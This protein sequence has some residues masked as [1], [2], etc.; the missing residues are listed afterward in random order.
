MRLSNVSET[1]T[2]RQKY[3]GTESAVPV[4][5]LTVVTPH[6]TTAVR[7]L[8]QSVRAALSRQ[9]RI[10]LAASGGLDS[11]ALLDAAAST[12]PRDRLTIATFD[13][14]TGPAATAACELVA[15]RAASLGVEF[16]AERAAAQ[17]TSE[18]AFRTARWAFLRA[19]AAKREA[20]IATAHTEDDQIETILMRVMRDAGARGLAALYAESDVLRPFVR[21][22]R[23]ALVQYARAQALVWIED[24]SNV[25]RAYLRN[26]VRHE[27]LPALR[28]VW[29][30][31]DRDLL[32][33]ARDAA[34]LRREIEAH[35]D[36]IDGL[37]VLSSGRGLDAPVAAF[38]SR[39]AATLFWPAVAAKAR[40][41]LD[42]RGL[43]RLVAFTAASRVGSRIQLA[44]GWQVVRSR[45]AFQVRESNMNASDEATPAALALSE[46]T[47]WG[48]WSFRAGDP[49]V[50][51]DGDS[52]SAW[53]PSDRP[54]LV[55]RWG[56]GDAMIHR[57]GS[58]PR[59]VK[60]LLTAAG[61]TGHQRAGWPVVVAG[62]Q[63]VW[64]PGVRRGVAA[65]ARSGRPGL[66]F[67]CEY[68][69]R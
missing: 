62:D 35:V 10:V 24:P 52:W 13:H 31:A 20:R 44:G 19:A 43:D 55:R 46:E 53:L 49:N 65:T 22:K 5:Y 45:D 21:V 38:P 12:V 37:A 66:T 40:I 36:R 16:V 67:T 61:V 68:N 51:N 17:L 47:R 64:I 4:E 14:G 6:G 2:E 56:P 7:Q 30:E 54:L 9:G 57:A 27:L 63:I 28:R 41:T 34:R 58:R 50:A 29:P 11:M 69:L 15:R 1:N 3:S 60:Q 8:R 59:K 32:S 39:D 25:S 23:S 42:R 18:E 33:I 48:D 26:R